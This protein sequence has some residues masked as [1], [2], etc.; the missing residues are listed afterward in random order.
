MLKIFLLVPIK[1]IKQ[2]FKK[3]ET[4][5]NE[6]QLQEDLDDVDSANMNNI[7]EQEG[8]SELILSKSKKR[9]FKYKSKEQ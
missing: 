8:E 3:V 2:L 6:L 9:K 5:S 7:M 1:E 4:F